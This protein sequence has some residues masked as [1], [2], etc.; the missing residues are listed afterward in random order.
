MVSD[1]RFFSSIRRWTAPRLGLVAFRVLGR[2]D[3]DIVP[4]KG[5]EFIVNDP[6]APVDISIFD[7]KDAPAPPP[8]SDGDDGSEDE[9]SEGEALDE[10]METKQGGSNAGPPADFKDVELYHWP[11]PRKKPGQKRRPRR[12]P[13]PMHI[14]L[15]I[16]QENPKS[17]DSKE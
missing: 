1:R 7:G 3:A 11:R 8:D 2:L 6:L 15:Q 10:E 12:P 16:Q 13:L 9:L 4:P 14:R 17:G 5:E